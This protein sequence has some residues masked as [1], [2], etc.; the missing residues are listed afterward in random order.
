[1][2][3]E[4]AKELR[5]VGFPQTYDPICEHQ[6]MLPKGIAWDGLYAW[7]HKETCDQPGACAPTLPELIEACGGGFKCLQRTIDEEM[8]PAWEVMILDV[9]NQRPITEHG[10]TPKEAVA[11]GWL[12][13]NA[14]KE[15]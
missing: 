14:P 3:H 5:D 8:Q 4:L 11:K 13:L 6:R 7:K 12:A 1:M 15:K 9:K 10:A 2:N